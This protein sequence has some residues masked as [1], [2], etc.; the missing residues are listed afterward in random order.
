M[1]SS[2]SLQ[3]SQFMINI[4]VQP[5]SSRTR[6]AGMHGDAVKISIKEPPV[7]NKANK[8]VIQFIAKL[9]GVPRS[10]VSIKSGRYGRNKKV[11]I[12]GINTLKG[13]KTLSTALSNA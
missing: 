7:D 3:D 5:R 4:Y 12:K 9:F 11:L 10:D 2:T 13:Q 6:V 8:A 1:D